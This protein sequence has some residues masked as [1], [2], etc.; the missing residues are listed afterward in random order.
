MKKIDFERANALLGLFS[1]CVNNGPLVS[2]IQ[3]EVAEELKA[4]NEECRQN[5][6]ERADETR[7]REQVAEQKRLEAAKERRKEEEQINPNPQ[8][9]VQPTMPGEPVPQGDP[10]SQPS[11]TDENADGMEDS[12]EDEVAEDENEVDEPKVDPIVRRPGI[13]PATNPVRRP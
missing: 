12:M 2:H 11:R 3:G 9:F 13:A 5:A 6:L 10:L 1:A 4:I 7:K 8:P